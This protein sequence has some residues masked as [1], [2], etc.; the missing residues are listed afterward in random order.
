[1]N[2]DVFAKKNEAAQSF[3]GLFLSP[4]EVPGEWIARDS[5]AT[6][7]WLGNV[8]GSDYFVVE[9]A[10]GSMKPFQLNETIACASLRSIGDKMTSA[11]DAAFYATA[12][13]FLHF[14]RTNGFCS[15][16]GSPTKDAKLGA[17]R[18]CTNQACGAS[19]YPRIDAATIMLV[20]CGDFALLGRK[21]SWPRGRWSTLAGFTEVGETLEQCCAREVYEEA[22]VA[23]DPSSIQFVASQPWPFPQ[24]FMVGFEAQAEPGPD[25]ELPAIDFDEK[26]LEDVRW[27]ERG[28]V[29]AHLEGGS[30]ALDFVPNPTESEF[31]IPGKSSLAR[32][33]ITKWLTGVDKC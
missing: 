27:F 3:D 16:C 29:Q 11:E 2:G 12:N 7:A 19:V 10:D 32:V 26:E 25:G 21:K 8:R 14:H 4:S 15:R 24:S 18:R 28:Y 17:C 13:A 6:T 23:V 22:G 31:H 9:L 33:L 1:M 30:A 5:T 20:T